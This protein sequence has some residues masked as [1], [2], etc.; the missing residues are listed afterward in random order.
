MVS[1][2]QQQHQQ[3]Q[4][5]QHQQHQQQH[6]QQHH[7]QHH[8][9]QQDHDD[10][11][12]D[13]PPPP[14]KVPTTPNNQK[15][16]PGPLPSLIST[17][18]ADNHEQLV[19]LLTLDPYSNLPLPAPPLTTASNTAG[20]S[21][22]SSSTSRT[23]TQPHRQRLV[24]ASE[25]LRTLLLYH[26]LPDPSDRSLIPKNRKKPR[27]PPSSSKAKDGTRFTADEEALGLTRAN[28]YGIVGTRLLFPPNDAITGPT[29][30]S[31]GYNTLG[32][33]DGPSPTS[34]SPNQ[35]GEAVVQHHATTTE[36]IYNPHHDP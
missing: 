21:I 24:F 5:Q 22:A 3:Q 27:K 9:Q 34:S 35:R 10:Q 31:G 13:H 17:L 25:S 29:G 11:H 15:R 20:K 14:V 26:V 36:T 16:P 33:N 30:A 1:Q 4:Y 6:Q 12:A 32:P 8:Q 7:Q 18:R 19:H 2:Q 23:V 28:P